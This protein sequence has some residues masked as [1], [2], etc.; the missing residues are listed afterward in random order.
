MVHL[1]DLVNSHFD[2]LVAWWLVHLFHRLS[3]LNQP[4]GRLGLAKAARAE[5][6]H[7]PLVGRRLTAHHVYPLVVDIQLFLRSCNVLGGR[8][9]VFGFE[10]TQTCFLLAAR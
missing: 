2:M 4:R 5:L 6:L 7:D 8:L 9:S 1:V 10:V 3:Q